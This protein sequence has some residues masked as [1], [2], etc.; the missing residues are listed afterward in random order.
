MNPLT[1]EAT[2][3]VTVVV[4]KEKEGSLKPERR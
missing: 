2:I 4:A 1:K 3:N